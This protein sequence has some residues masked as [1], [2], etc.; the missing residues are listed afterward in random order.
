MQHFPLGLTQE[1][2]E[3]YKKVY[4]ITY[5]LNYLEC[6]LQYIPLKSIDVLEVGGGLPP[7][8]VLD[9]LGCNSWTGVEELS[10]YREAG[11]DYHFHRN[12]QN[13]SAQME[14]AGRYKL[15]FMRIEE[16]PEDH[17][18]KYDLVFSIASF[19]HMDR[20]PLALEKM[21]HCLKPGGKLFTMFSPIWSAFD[22]HH[23]PIGIPDRFDKSLE[24]QN[25]IFR[26]WGHLLQTRT[27]A[28]LDLLARFDCRFAEEIIYYTYNSNQINRYFSEDYINIFRHSRFQVELCQ[29]TFIS[30]I[31]N[32]I[33]F[34]LERR[35]PDYRLFN[36]N[37]I[38]GILSK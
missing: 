25:Y 35:Y 4:S 13:V 10:Y 11:Y 22:G 17:F 28:Y 27:K 24:H 32:E 19:E 34:E 30:P 31:D 7:S 36:N 33:Q 26:P 14:Y 9:H 38:L 23:L 6:C 5:H 18:G 16:I 1:Q 12:D 37:G 15:L 2:L 21:F 20:L 8:L 3:H 29:P